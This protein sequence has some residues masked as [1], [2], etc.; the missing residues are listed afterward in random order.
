MA[1]ELKNYSSAWLINEMISLCNIHRLRYKVIGYEKFERISEE[2][3]IYKIVVNPK[4]GVKFCIIAGVHGSEIAGPFAILEML[5]NPKK[6]FNA[7]IR[8]DIFPLL[9]PSGFD[10]GQRYDDDHRDP[11]CL[12]KKTLKSKNYHEIQAFNNQTKNKNFDA[13]IS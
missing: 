11:N 3:P 6:Y 7:K 9:N 4:K 12:N 2:Y 1:T 13:L 10:L 8:Y 5:K